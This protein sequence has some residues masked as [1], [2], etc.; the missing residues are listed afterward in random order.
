MMVY[1]LI[2]ELIEYPANTEIV[3]ECNDES[4]RNCDFRYSRILGE[5]H[6]KLE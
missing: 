2:R 4:T 5:V 3:F 6:I 1:E